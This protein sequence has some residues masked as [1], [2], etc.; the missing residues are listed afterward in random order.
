MKTNYTFHKVLP[1]LVILGFLISATPVSGASIISGPTTRSTQAPILQQSCGVGVGDDPTDPVPPDVTQAFT[2]A[3]SRIGGE[4][5]IGQPTNCVHRWWKEEGIMNWVQDFPDIPGWGRSVIFWNDNRQEAYV[6]HGWIYEK[7]LETDGP[8]GWLGEPISDETIAPYHFVSDENDPDGHYPW[9]YG[10]EPLSYFERGFISRKQGQSE[11]SANTYPPAICDVQVQVSEENGQAKLHATTTAY[12]VPGYPGAT[13]QTDPFDVYLAIIKADGTREW[14]KMTENSIASFSLDWDSLPL[15]ENVHIYLDAWNW[16]GKDQGWPAKYSSYPQNVVLSPDHIDQGDNYWSGTRDILSPLSMINGTNISF[17][18]DNLLCDGGGLA[19]FS[20]LNIRGKVTDGIEDSTRTHPANAPLADITVKLYPPGS[21]VPLSTVYTHDDG[22]YEFLDVPWAQNYKIEVILV[23]S[24]QHLQIHYGGQIRG[25]EWEQCNRQKGDLV[26]FS[27]TMS[28]TSLENTVDFNL[29]QDFD[30]FD[31]VSD[32]NLNP[33]PLVSHKDDLADIGAIYFHLKQA[34]D[35]AR[36]LLGN[37]YPVEINTF[38]ADVDTTVC[39]DAFATSYQN[40]PIIVFS[41]EFSEYGIGNYRPISREWH[42]YFHTMQPGWQQSTCGEGSDLPH[43]GYSNSTTACDWREGFAE[44]WSAVLWD[45]IVNGS[46]KRPDVIIPPYENYGLEYPWMTMMEESS[47]P[48]YEEMAIAATLWDIY[49]SVGT[50]Y[51]KTL[52][53][54]GPENIFEDAPYPDNIELSKAEIWSVIGQPL[55]KML[56]V[57][58]AFSY[59]SGNLNYEIDD[60]NLIFAQHGFFEDKEPLNFTW[61]PPNERIGYGGR[62]N[63]PNPPYEPKTFIEI[64]VLDTNNVV[65]DNA[66]LVVSVSFPGPYDVYNFSYSQPLPTRKNNSARLA[67]P[68]YPYIASVK[69]YV[70]ADGVSSGILEIE[71]MDFWRAV[72]NSKFGYGQDYLQNCIGKYTFVIGDYT[73]ISF[74]TESPVTILNQFGIH[75][76][77]DWALT[78]PVSTALTSVDAVVGSAKVEFSFNNSD[79]LTYTGTFTASHN[80]T[81]YYRATDWL[82][83]VEPTQQ[84]TIQ[85]DTATPTST[86][87]LSPTLPYSETF[88]TDVTLAL[89]GSDEGPSGLDYIEYRLN[90]GAWLHYDSDNLP[91]I[92]QNGAN[93]V[94]YRAVDVAGNVEVVHRATITLDKAVHTLILLDQTQSNRE[95][96]LRAIMNAFWNNQMPLMATEAFNVMQAGNSVVYPAGTAILE[97][98]ISGNFTRQVHIGPLSL[99]TGYVLYAQMPVIFNSASTDE[100]ASW[101]QLEMG[102]TLEDALNHTDWPRVDEYD[103]VSGTVTSDIVF[104]PAG[105]TSDVQWIFT[106]SG[107]SEALLAQAQAGRWFVCQGD[108]CL[109]VQQAGLVPTGTLSADDTLSAGSSALVPV[110]ENAILTYNW[111]EAMTLTRYSDTPRFTLS[112][113]LVRIANYADND[114]AAIVRRRIGNGGVILIGG[115]ASANTSTYGLLYHAMFTA[116]EEQVSA[117]VSVEQQFMPGTPPDVVPGLEP[118]IP[119]LVRTQLTNHGMTA[120]QNFQYSEFITEAFHLLASPTATVGTVLTLPVILPD[121]VW[122]TWTVDLLPP[123]EHEMTYMA[124]NVA[125]DTLKP[126]IVTV[127]QAQFSYQVENE[128]AR[129][130]QLNRPD[131]VVSALL[132]PLIVHNPTKEPDNTYP[133]SSDGFYHHLRHEMENKLE[134]RANNLTHTVT[135]PLISIIQDAFDQTIFPT[136]KHYGWY[137]PIVVPDIEETHVFVLNTAM[138]YPDRDYPIPAGTS[139]SE[140]AYS[141]KDWDGLTW[142][143][144]PNPRHTFVHIPFEYRALIKKESGNGDLWVPG[145]TLTFD[146]GTML[147]YDQLTPPL[148]YLIHSQE[149][150]GRGVSF[151]VEPV[152]DTLVLE[153]SGGSVYT[154]I[155][156]DP[157]PF[158][159]YFPE[160]AINN[161]LTPTPS[162][163]TYT[164]LWGRT[165]TLTETVRSSFYDIIPYPK[166]SEA[167]GIKVASTHEIQGENGNRLPDVAAAQV[168]TVTY[169]IK[170]ESLNRTLA[171]EQLILQELLPRGLG[172]NIEFLSWESSNGSF[173]LLDEYSFQYPAFELLS[174]QGALPENEPQ[175]LTIT[176]RLRTYPEHVREG[177]FLVDGGVRFAAPVEA[178]GPGQYDTGITHV[179]VEQGYAA[180]PEVVKRV[181]E[182]QVPRQGGVAHELIDISALTDIQRYW[183]EVYVDSYGGGDKA[184]TVRVGGSWG[185]DLHFATVEAG[186]ETY[187]VYEI[188]NNS[189]QTWTNVGLE[190]VAPTGITLTPIFTDSLEPPP[191]VYDTPYLWATEIPDIARGVYYYKVHVDEGVTPGVMYPIVFTLTGD[192]VPD[193]VSFPL[194]VARVGVGGEVQ[195]ILGQ[196]Y[197]EQIVDRSPEYVTP[198][199]AAIATAEQLA[200]T[201]MYTDTEQ[202]AAFFDTLTQDVPF[203]YTVLPDATRLITYTIPNEWQTLPQQEGVEMSGEWT[204]LVRSEITATEPGYHLVNYG[205][206]LVGVDSFN[207]PLTVSGNRGY[208]TV[209]GPALSGTYTIL[210]TTSPF[211]GG[212]VIDPLP[213]EIVD[214]WVDIDIRNLGNRIAETPEISATIN[215]TDGIEIIDV[216]PEPTSIISGVITWQLPSLLPYGG[217]GDKEQDVEHLKVQLRF[218]P[219]DSAEIRARLAR[220]ETTPFYVPLLLESSAEYAY[221][222]GNEIFTVQS[223][224]GGEF[225]LHVGSDPLPAPDLQSAVWDHDRERTLLNWSAIDGARDYVVYRSTEP[226]RNFRQVGWVTDGTAMENRIYDNPLGPVYYYV[227]RARNDTL[228]EGRHSQVVAIYTNRYFEVYLPLVMR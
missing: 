222:W 160:A 67:L 76:N 210:T 86:L 48:P 107:A 179:R 21:E 184:A 26:I 75:G 29:T 81:I 143:R 137:R 30:K 78:N 23:D 135:I 201:E 113:D 166:T 100:R 69:I 103:L 199:A 177:S 220:L 155:G 187:L 136:I 82:E 221:H 101:E 47:S 41:S 156:Q 190:Y 200:T 99:P 22:S 228:V 133:L 145:I 173:V 87:S 148:R 102:L 64:S 110:E 118:D 120:V 198:V 167:V 174:F 83:N 112:G 31:V 77:V 59:A 88:T 55:D 208:V 58:N 4:S 7:Y 114:E 175:M 170:A 130:V 126:G 188:T 45:E 15:D 89:T 141:L 146:L 97:G 211:Y 124:A 216:V 32:T 129:T 92:T 49:D 11:F 202:W 25:E 215:L 191:N 121:G 9:S 52:V 189:G 34:Q 12:R 142:V 96:A 20:P 154:G 157:I 57:Y 108:G 205:P 131:A 40:K 139:G 2:D 203:T 196:T 3:Y 149:L 204:L 152:T 72:R 39:S 183:E 138:G 223:G 44:F 56:D 84:V 16:H 63:R 60:L 51:R 171:Q 176:A 46:T 164:D 68:R 105:V 73:H 85:I 61:D 13:G 50:D 94:E 162:E 180:N 186:G 71:G 53:Q 217:V 5:V 144:I 168:L 104:I 65:V 1:A 193:A 213:G 159:E 163:I 109:L 195:Y 169:M 33:R 127:G 128:A 150:F 194:P 37:S 226:D 36:D 209:S 116:G 119:V 28:P 74:D 219:P 178:G 91:I 158:R 153:G 62:E 79:W 172:Y 54:M 207:V 27:R 225:G 132:P 123:G 117:Q 70:E 17:P 181:A 192:N 197:A 125:T 10:G 218:T 115:H 185:K 42:E 98:E 95:S 43:H 227:I 6:I 14:R 134:T 122:I 19:F 38:V 66:N 8:L 224:L 106:E 140:W 165:H 151:S 147:A 111:P 161:P 206:Q 90:G 80:D 35:F 212:I 93:I 182:A 18:N 24:Q 214:A